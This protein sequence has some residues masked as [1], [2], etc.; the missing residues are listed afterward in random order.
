MQSLG[1]F[2]AKLF[3]Q[4]IQ[5]SSRPILYLLSADCPVF[6]PHRSIGVNFVNYN[7][8]PLFDVNATCVTK[9]KTSPAKI[10]NDNKATVE[11]EII[12]DFSY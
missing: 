5:F 1:L 7:L 3:R 8:P 4:G 10:N 2:V 11:K 6:T 12:W 9:I